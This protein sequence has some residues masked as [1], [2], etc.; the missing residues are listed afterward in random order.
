MRNELQEFGF[1]DADFAAV[2]REQVAHIAKSLRQRE[3]EIGSATQAI[4]LQI[5]HQLMPGSDHIEHAHAKLLCDLM[6]GLQRVNKV[7]GTVR[8][9]DLEESHEACFTAAA[10]LSSVPVSKALA[11]PEALKARMRA[12]TR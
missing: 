5:A 12:L 8:G 1:S 6:Q 4:D 7:S 10:R 3:R 11:L 9:S 2:R